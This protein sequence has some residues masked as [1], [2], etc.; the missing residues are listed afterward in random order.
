M[1]IFEPGDGEPITGRRIDMGEKTTLEEVRD[2]MRAAQYDGGMVVTPR[3]AK[4]VA[5]A[6]DAHLATPAQ[7]VDVEAI[8][9]VKFELGFCPLDRAHLRDL[10]DKLSQAIVDKPRG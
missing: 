10:A 8:R 5:D 9:E 4:N 3:E 6:I 2:R 7:T 1:T